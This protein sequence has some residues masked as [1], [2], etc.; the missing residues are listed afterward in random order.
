MYDVHTFSY[1]FISFWIAAHRQ[2]W[3][4]VWGWDSCQQT[5]S[6][7]RLACEKS[8]APT[9]AL[10]FNVRIFPRCPH[11]CRRLYS[12]ERHLIVLSVIRGLMSTPCMNIPCST[13]ISTFLLPTSYAMIFSLLEPGGIGSQYTSMSEADTA[14]AHTLAGASEGSKYNIWWIMHVGN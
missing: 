7:T 12:N 13:I 2:P 14:R 4:W 3:Y 11:P 10:Y 6:S 8:A 9:H 5:S 1:L